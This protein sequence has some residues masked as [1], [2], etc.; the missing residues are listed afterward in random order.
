MDFLRQISTQ[1]RLAVGGS[2]RDDVISF[3]GPNDFFMTTNNTV[4]LESTEN[5]VNKKIQGVSVIYF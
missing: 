1:H 5:E 2:E 4:T 3:R